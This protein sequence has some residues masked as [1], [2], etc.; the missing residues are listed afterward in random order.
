MR[1]QLRTYPDH[2]RP[3]GHRSEAVKF[4]SRDREGTV[5]GNDFRPLPHGRG[6]FLHS[7]SPAAGRGATRRGAV[8]V[9]M[10]LIVPFLVLLL[11][12]I[13]EIGQTLRVH[14]FL[15]EASRQGCTAGSLSGNS[16]ADVI[17]DVK[18]AL[19]AFKLNTG[20]AVVTIRV[21]DVVG[22]VAQARRNDKITVTVA[23]PMSSASWT[24]S[25]MFVSRRS[26]RSETTVM[27]R[28]G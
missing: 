25:S 7:L 15:S 1:L 14:S 12:G 5:H 2:H 18:I 3:S 8:V 17:E 22:N 21:N 20:A 23:I 6:S 24:G 10:A 28:Q 4:S 13:C 11:L 9:E 27:L 16:N 26:I 19:S